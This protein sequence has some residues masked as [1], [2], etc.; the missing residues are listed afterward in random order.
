MEYISIHEISE[1][2]NMKERKVTAF[3]REGRIAG[4]KKFGKTWM[5][6]SDALMPLDKRTKDFENYEL[7][8]E[9]DNRFIPYTM[10]GGEERVVSY[11]RD[12]YLKSPMC[13]AFTPYRICPLGAHVDHNLGKITGF[14]ID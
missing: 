4:A 12:K 8:I 11:Y 3:C 14:S 7:E 13:T 10:S 9:S 1:K 5:I 2:W 6:P